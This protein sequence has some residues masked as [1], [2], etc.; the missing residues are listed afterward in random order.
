MKV[1]VVIPLSLHSSLLDRCKNND[2]EFKLLKNGVV[3]RSDG[4]EEVNIL[5]SDAQAKSLLDFIARITPEGLPDVQ[6]INIRFDL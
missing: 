3:R 4:Q 2:P 1:I 6:Q 5:C